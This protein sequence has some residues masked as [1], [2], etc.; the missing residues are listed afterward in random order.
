MSR[1]CS[2]FVPWR[3]FEV[4]FVPEEQV[5]SFHGLYQAAYQAD[6]DLAWVMAKVLSE[7]KNEN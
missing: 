7:D 1:I 5:F 3:P 6:E 2:E 4:V